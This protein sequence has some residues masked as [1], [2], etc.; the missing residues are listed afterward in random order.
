V[1]ELQKEVRHLQKENDGLRT[2]VQESAQQAKKTQSRLGEQIKDKNMQ[3]EDDKMQIEALR[4][5]IAEF[6]DAVD[7][8]DHHFFNECSEI[9]KDTATTDAQKY[10][11]L[12]A[13][14][15]KFKSMRVDTN[16][17]EFDLD[18]SQALSSEDAKKLVQVAICDRFEAGQASIFRPTEEEACS[19]RQ[20]DLKKSRS[21]MPINGLVTDAIRAMN[22]HTPGFYINDKLLGASGTT[23]GTPE[24]LGKKAMEAWQLRQQ[25]YISDY[26]KGTMKVLFSKVPGTSFYNEDTA[27][28]KNSEKN[29]VTRATFSGTQQVSY[30]FFDPALEMDQSREEEQHSMLRVAAKIPLTMDESDREKRIHEAAPALF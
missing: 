9:E 6:K 19:T 8:A 21:Y 24:G 12:K 11:F 23:G 7:N 15:A 3:M 26:V 14:L 1:D 22:K 17:H 13:A 4:C 2:Q 29:R 10:H 16:V 30:F 25:R 18:T 28:E 5:E 27:R 20:A